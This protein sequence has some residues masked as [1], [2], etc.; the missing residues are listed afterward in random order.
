MRESLDTRERTKDSRPLLL[1]VPFSGTCSLPAPIRP[2][3]THRKEV[4]T[5][6]VEFQVFQKEACRPRVSRAATRRG[7]VKAG[8]QS[9]TLG[10]VV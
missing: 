6:F 10:K 9:L 1:P 8:A 5:N 4:E 3:A 2:A 7:N